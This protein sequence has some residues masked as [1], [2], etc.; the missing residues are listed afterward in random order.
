MHSGR[1]A[2]RRWMRR[3]SLD[4]APTDETAVRPTAEESNMPINS[5]QVDDDDGYPVTP[6]KILSLSSQERPVLL[7]ALVLNI[8]SE[9]VSMVEPLLL[10]VAYEAV[11]EG[12]DD[13]EEAG[14]TQHTLTRVFILVLCLH[15]ASSVFGFLA[16]CAAGIAGE[17]AVSRL[18]Y[19][20][21]EHLLAQEMSFFDSQKT[22]D[23]VSRLSTDTL[24]VQEGITRR[25]RRRRQTWR[26]RS[27]RASGYDF[28][29]EPCNFRA[30]GKL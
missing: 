24:L 23:L 27:P 1:C 19:R 6:G 16:G 28:R 3:H 25:A 17:R 21:Y 20:L 7:V 29:S 5:E 10:A 13:A 8:L 4:E 15:V 14:A 2:M 11:V 22:G 30:C 9:G 18:R 26:P 12:Y